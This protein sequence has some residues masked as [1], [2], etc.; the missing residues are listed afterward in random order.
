MMRRAC[1]IASMRLCEGLDSGY[2]YLHACNMKSRIIY[3]LLRISL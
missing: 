3:I 1:S 2:N